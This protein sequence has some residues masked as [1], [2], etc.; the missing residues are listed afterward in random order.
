MRTLQIVGLAVLLGLAVGAEAGSVYR[1]VGPNGEVIFS[2]LPPPDAASTEQ[3]NLLAPVSE[4]R[5][6]Q[7]EERQQELMD[8][9]NQG[10]QD[11]EERSAARTSAVN[12]AVKAVNEA[13][14]QLEQAKA[15]R[16]SDW[17]GGVG[18]GQ[19]KP[20]YDERVKKAQEAVDAAERNLSLV[21]SGQK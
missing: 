18:S 11:R 20:G 8:L 16:P 2:D 7:A 19:L 1:S 14:Q 4:E 6:Q 10:A 15:I 9:V 5:R 13:R 21:R 12:E 3:V 17:W